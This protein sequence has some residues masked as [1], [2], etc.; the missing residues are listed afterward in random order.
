MNDTSS[1]QLKIKRLQ[2]SDL[3]QYNELLRYAFQVTQKEL[4]EIG[5]EYDEIRKAKSPILEHASVLGWFDGERLAS[6]ISIYPMKMNIHSNIYDIGLITGVATYPEYACQ[7]LMSSLMKVC[8]KEMREKGQSI[9]LLYPYSIPLYRKKGWEL[10]AD[11]M[12]FSV[13]DFQ[14]PKPQKIAGYVRRVSENSPTLKE[15]HNRFAGLTHGCLIRNDL[16]WQEYW[17][18]DSDDTTVAIY[19]SPENEPSGY[20]VYRL[21]NEIFYVKEMVYLNRQAW[22]GLW[23]YISAHEPMLTEVRG[24]NYTG[25][26]I[27]FWLP[28]SDVKETVRPYVMGRIIDVHAFIKDYQFLTTHHQGSLVFEVSDH[29]CEWNNTSFSVK[30]EPNEAPLIGNAA[31]GNAIALTIQ[32]LATLLL[33]YKRPRELH[34]MGLLEAGDDVI[35]ILEA[36][37]PWNKAYISDYI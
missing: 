18:W 24:N 32:S 21:D 26:S 2:P 14:L 7:G 1:N 8:L 17:R 35:D 12:T 28:D 3:N 13:K 16:A 11:K 20:I 5:W 33:G 29:L 37:I 36:I 23:N 19:Y 6:Q 30:M 31:V 27:S 25:S 34:M 22:K 10:I 15:L 9:S 4:I